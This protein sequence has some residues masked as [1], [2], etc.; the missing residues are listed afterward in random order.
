MIIGAA[1]LTFF[2]IWVAV[3]YLIYYLLWTFWLMPSIHCQ[4]C[5]FKVK[6]TIE[7]SVTRKTSTKL[8]PK[9]KWVT[10]YLQ[11]HVASGKKWTFTFLILWL[12]P[13]FL[14]II[15]FFMNFSLIALLCLIGFIGLLVVMILHMRF[16]V[17]PTCAI[18]DEC[19]EAF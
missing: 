3:L 12:L 16:K 10:S 18:K 19:F 14:M 17:C 7:D 11:K 1:G 4:Y 2:N 13:I 6:E 5:Y 15:S 9:D 8:M